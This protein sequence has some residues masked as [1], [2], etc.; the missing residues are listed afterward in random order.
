LILID[1]I[2]ETSLTNVVSNLILR[3]MVSKTNA[4]ICNQS[5]RVRIG[6]LALNTRPGGLIEGNTVFWVAKT[7]W[8]NIESRIALNARCWISLSIIPTI[9]R[10]ANSI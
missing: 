10:N 8:Q 1:R 3:A 2:V 7:T 6:S 5:E 4:L 9:L